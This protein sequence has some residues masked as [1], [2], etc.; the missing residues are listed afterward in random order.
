MAA[1]IHIGVSLK[2]YLSYSGTVSWLERVAEI[3]ATH[4]GLASGAVELF[5][6]PAAPA[7]AEASR[8]LAGTPVSVAAQDISQWDS[9]AYTG[10]TGAS[11][12]AEIG[13]TIAEIG[14]AERRALL[15][16]TDEIV[17]RKADAARSRGIVPL[18]C[19]G[20]AERG[21]AADNAALCVRQIR[22]AGPGALMVAYEP[23]W[24]IGAANPAPAEY[25]Q[26][27]IG[28]I[29][30]ALSPE[31]V[32]VLYGGSAGP[33]LL[34]SLRPAVDGLFLGRFAHDPANLLAVLDEA[35]ERHTDA[36]AYSL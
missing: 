1:T 2:A 3:A 5:V 21:D 22:A 35:S 4:P 36:D 11:I 27:T 17:R 30:A 6:A 34:A 31:S 33:G 13:V 12:L 20:E 19:V 28:A 32:T 16:E 18:L 7:L 10:E 26:A 14:H 9:G 15:H 23:L 29:R 25:V 24:A 8:L